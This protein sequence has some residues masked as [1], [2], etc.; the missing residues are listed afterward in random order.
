M[1]DLVFAAANWSRF[2]SDSWKI[3]TSVIVLFLIL[4]WWNWLMK[5]LGTF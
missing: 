1:H 3:A 5:N 2:W 4:G